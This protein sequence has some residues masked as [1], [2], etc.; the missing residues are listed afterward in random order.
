MDD[1]ER[2]TTAR[3]FIKAQDYETARTILQKMPN[4]TVAIKWLANLEQLL[5]QENHA[6]KPEP[7][8]RQEVDETRVCPYLR[9]FRDKKL[10]Y[11]YSTSQNGCYAGTDIAGIAYEH[12][13]VFCLNEHYRQCPVY[14][15]PL[16]TDDDFVIDYVEETPRNR[17]AVTRI[18]QRMAVQENE[19]RFSS[20][21]LGCY[22]EAI[23]IGVGIAGGLFIW[24]LLT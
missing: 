10:V 24:L 4:N 8:Q 21:R 5:I 15:Q 23:I 20:T 6:E 17:T 14:K 22:L 9:S 11:E 13:E 1:K 12:Q 3:K 19:K 18:E 2:L 7:I 16:L